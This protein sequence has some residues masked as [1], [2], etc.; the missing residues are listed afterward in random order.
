MMFSNG[1][2]VVWQRRRYGQ[3]ILY[4]GSSERIRT[5]VGGKGKSDHAHGRGF[6]GPEHLE[7]AKAWA[8]MGNA[9]GFV[10]QY[11]LETDG[12][13]VLDLS[14]DA[15]TILHWLALF[16]PIPQV[17][18]IHTGHATWYRIMMWEKFE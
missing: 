16:D 6:Y 7:L 5:P 17:L 11:E 4:P 13:H 18:C 8:C 1:F 3:K 10:N 15:Y 9:M 12:L 14:A 2:V